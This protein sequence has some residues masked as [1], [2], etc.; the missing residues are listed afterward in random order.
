M[1]SLT[2]EQSAVYRAVSA[3][4][5]CFVKACAT[6]DALWVCDLPRRMSELEEPEN[7]LKALGVCCHLDPKT[8]LW[9]LDWDA[10]SY[11]LLEERLPKAPPP[12]LKNP[13]WAEAYA[14]CRLLLLHS[15]P[16]EE[17]PMTMIRQTMKLPTR[18]ENEQIR[19]IRTLHGQCAQRLR[20]R[21]ALPSLAGG[22][23]AAWLME[24]N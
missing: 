16:L 13:Q 20:L 23:L 6:D 8:R 18:P 10:N 11:R 1:D 12:T 2:R 4:G 17:Q 24:N 14:L 21:E 3:Y 7:E 9:L 15:A 5:S 19:A 22:L